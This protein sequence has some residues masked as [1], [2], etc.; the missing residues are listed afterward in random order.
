A[1]LELL[2]Q[3]RRNVVDAAGND[4]LVE[5]RELLPAVIAVRVFA[6]DRL[7][8]GIA[9]LDQGVVDAAR[10]LG[11]GLDDLDRP[12]L[13]GDVRQVG[14]LMPRAGPDLE[15]LLAH[16]DVDGAGHAPDHPW[17]GDRHAVADVVVIDVV[18]HAAGPR[19]AEFLAWSHQE[20]PLVARFPQV[21][22]PDHV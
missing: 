20:R 5:R 11:Q 22:V 6:G 12:D 8:F 16:F 15:R 1:G 13:V 2:Q 17:S 4:D 19:P 9:A 10:A 21:D 18:D 3:R 14:S 7:V